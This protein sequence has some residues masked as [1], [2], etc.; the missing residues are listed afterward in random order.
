MNEIKATV[1][2][3]IAALRQEKGMTQL[4][5]AERLN[6]SDKAI[7][8]WERAESMPDISV[9]VGIAELFEVSLDMLVR[10][11]EPKKIEKKPVYRKGA[12]TALSILLVWL[13]AV[14][15]FVMTT[16]LSQSLKY[17][18]LSFIYAVPISL[19]VWLIFNSLWFR[20]RM[21]Y[22]I[23]SLLMWSLLASIQITLLVFGIDVWMI[24][25]LGIPG[26][27][28]IL[29]WSTIRRVKQ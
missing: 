12:I 23:I 20:P 5:L 19:I 2:K 25:L 10:G 17:Q 29:L 3:N 24:Y 26:Q 16:V 9:L 27:L 22:W 1:A 11:Q 4:E 14:L 15:V 21:N 7:S 8:K 18:W 6:Y 13:I 28:I